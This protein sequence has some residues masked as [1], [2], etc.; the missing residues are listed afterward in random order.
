MAV[1]VGFSSAGAAAFGAASRWATGAAAV[2]AVRRAVG[3]AVFWD[4]VVIGA[5]LIAA[6][7]NKWPTRLFQAE[8]VRR[9]ISVPE[10]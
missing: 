9:N 10:W 2:F 5:S 8:F 7:H 3:R 4:V 1:S 6:M